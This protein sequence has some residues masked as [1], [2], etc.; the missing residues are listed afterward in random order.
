[1]PDGVAPRHRV[2]VVDDDLDTRTMTADALGDR[3]H[4]AT[5]ATVAEAL[6]CAAAERPA[7]IVVDLMLAGE[8]GWDLIRSLREDAALRAVPVV[9]LSAT[10]ATEP[11]TG[12]GPW[13]AYLTKP[14]P[15]GRL[16]E[17]LAALL[18]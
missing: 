14:C 12:I 6:A 10:P 11:P 9:V 15:M 7:A 13:A 8:S 18:G 4:V 16:R 5:A 17:V 2:L 3:Y 1:M